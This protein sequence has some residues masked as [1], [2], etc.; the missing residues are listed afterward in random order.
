MV[1]AAYLPL[2]QSKAKVAHQEH[3]PIGELLGPDRESS[4][5]EYKS[6]LRTHDADGILYK[7]LESAML[8]TIAAFLNSRDGGTLLI[9]VADDG[10]V[11]GLVADY[12]SLH[13]DG[14]DDRDR[15]Q[16]HLAN[17][18]SASMG[19]AAATNVTTQVQTI[20]EQDLCRVHVRP[21]GFPVD[22]TVTVDTK[23][24][25]EK[26]TAFY[27]RVGNGTKELDD[28]QKAKYVSQRW[29]NT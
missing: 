17:I 3:C 21:S 6:T 10:T 12:A 24:Q 14:K 4:T 26:R 11:H 28:A 13:K 18:I 9:G 1:L 27:V 7:P 19:E 23:G 16:L 25:M 8:K 2:I 15:F 20:D 22:A 29:G 5:L